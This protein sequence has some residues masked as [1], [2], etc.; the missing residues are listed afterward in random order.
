MIINII[1]TNYYKKIEM[2]INCVA[3]IKLIIS[4]MQQLFLF[5]AQNKEQ[6]S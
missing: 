1:F 4:I 6:T 2:I 3:L 5:K